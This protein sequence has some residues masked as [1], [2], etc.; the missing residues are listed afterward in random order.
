MVEVQELCRRQQEQDSVCDL[1]AEKIVCRCSQAS[2]GLVSEDRSGRQAG[3]PRSSTP[4]AG[5]AK[6]AKLEAALRAMPEDD[7][8]FANERTAIT[9]R[10]Q[11]R[12][13]AH[14]REQAYWCAY[15]R[16]QK[17]LHTRTAASE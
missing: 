11:R 2:R 6:L 12:K 9:R 3:F 16:S 8:D 4:K 1:W 5:K 14:G 13:Q 10:L 17:T 15:R 7:E